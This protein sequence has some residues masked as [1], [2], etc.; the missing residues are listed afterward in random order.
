M[1]INEYLKIID[2]VNEKG[3]Y[4]PDWQS[5]AHHKVPAWYMKDKV[6]V[7]IHWGIY[8]V[9]AYGNEWYS[10]NMYGKESP[11]YEHHINRKDT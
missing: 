2:E 7:F 8:S 5:L 4:K 9:P 10:R 1:D 6:G 3:R 11:E